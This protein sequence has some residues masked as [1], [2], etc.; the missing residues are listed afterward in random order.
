MQLLQLLRYFAVRLAATAAASAFRG[1]DASRRH[2][3]PLR[4]RPAARLRHA[5]SEVL[6]RGGR[7]PPSGGSA[8]NGDDKE[9][10]SQ[11][12]G[13]SRHSPSLLPQC[14]CVCFI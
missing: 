1:P 5:A 2:H 6:P 8:G 9:P 10:R 13:K 4:Q 11:N 14:V 7:V 3:Q 12:A